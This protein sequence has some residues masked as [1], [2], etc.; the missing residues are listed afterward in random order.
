MTVVRIEQNDTEAKVVFTRGGK[1]ESLTCDRVVCAIGQVERREQS[2]GLAAHALV[3]HAVQP[4]DQLEV[5]ARRE[6]AVERRALRDERQ[7]SPSAERVGG[8][9][10][11]ADAKNRVG[12]KLS[13][14]FQSLGNRC[15]T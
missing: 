3:R 14:S 11:A 15:V 5:T 9:V 10:C 4:A 8:D 1:H 13:G 12:S 2:F 6:V 7:L